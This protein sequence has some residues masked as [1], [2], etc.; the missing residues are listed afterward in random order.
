MKRERR[1]RKGIKK[2]KRKIK[3]RKI[4]NAKILIVV[5]KKRNIK[6]IRTNLKEKDE[7]V[8][9]VEKMKLTIKRRK[10]IIMIEK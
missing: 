8:G 2:K 1:K 7:E 9:Q 5:V 4:K 3:R 6:K 10:M